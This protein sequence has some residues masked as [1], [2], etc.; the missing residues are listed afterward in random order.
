MHFTFSLY[1]TYFSGGEGT[2][3]GGVLFHGG[4]DHEFVE[5]V[6]GFGEGVGDMGSFEVEVREDGVL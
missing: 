4:E 3:G 5:E 6:A 1:I 2:I